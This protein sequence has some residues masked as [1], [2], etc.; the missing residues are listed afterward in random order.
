M[1]GTLK[2]ILIFLLTINFVS[3]QDS[4]KVSRLSISDLNDDFSPFIW[5]ENLVFTSE[6]P[7]KMFLIEYS[8]SKQN[9]GVSSIF[10]AR[11]IN[12]TT[13]SSPES[14]SKLI[15]SNHHDGPASFTLDNKY[16]YYS[17]PRDISNSAEARNNEEN[18]LAIFE[19]EW[20]GKQ[21][22]NIKRMLCQ[23]YLR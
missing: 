19:S 10:K 11:I 15:Q 5:N 2:F 23:L 6:R 7:N 16:I 4:Y 3:A 1:K 18:Y 21:W 20:D 13:F 12:D 14:F 17:R 9:S 22:K 8:D